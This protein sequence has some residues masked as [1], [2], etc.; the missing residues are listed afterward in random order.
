[1]V[2]ATRLDMTKMSPEAYRHLLQLEGLISH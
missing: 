2:E 1:M